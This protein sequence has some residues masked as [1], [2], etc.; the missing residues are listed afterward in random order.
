V[1]FT[2]EQNGVAQRKNRTLEKMARTMMQ[3]KNLPSTFWAE[4]I[5]TSVYLLNRCP[6]KAVENKTPFEAWSGGWK[7]SVNHLRIF[8][9]IC[10]AHVPREMRHKLEEKGEK[11]VFVG[12][13]SKSKGYRLFSLKRNKVIISRD[14]IFDENSKWD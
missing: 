6:T 5:Y 14:V 12:Y 9:S 2:S 4:A 1:S 8:G 10:Y 3:E 11:C 7:P 13:S